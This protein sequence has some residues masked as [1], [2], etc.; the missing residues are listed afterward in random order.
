M[1]I[2]VKR[3][4]APQK[5][6]PHWRVLK[7]PLPAPPEMMVLL[8]VKGSLWTFQ[9]PRSRAL[10]RCELDA[11]GNE[12][13]FSYLCFLLGLNPQEAFSM[14]RTRGELKHED[15]QG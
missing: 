3:A 1:S 8:E 14:I 10:Y 13:S 5:T 7:G 15:C 6:I 2:A 4:K 12:R 11:A 9:H